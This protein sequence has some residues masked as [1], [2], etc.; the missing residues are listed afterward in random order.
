MKDAAFAEH[1]EG[2]GNTEGA[3]IDLGEVSKDTKGGLWGFDDGG[4]GL[5]WC[6]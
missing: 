3:L 4:A 5:C 6:F 1:L 2:Q